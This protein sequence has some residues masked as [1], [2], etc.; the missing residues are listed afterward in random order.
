MTF[1][2]VKVEKLASYGLE[3]LQRQIV[4]PS[5]ITIKSGAEFQGALGDAIT[6]KIGARTKARRAKIRPATEAER[7]IQFSDLSEQKTHVTLTDRIYSAVGLEDEKAKLDVEDVFSQVVAPQVRAIAVDYENL[8]A[9]EIAGAPY[10]HVVPVD[11]DHPYEA[12]VEA[13]RLLGLSFVPDENR[14]L[15]VGANFEAALRK[16]PQ[17]I[18]ATSAGDAIASS[19]LA[20]AT[21]GTINGYTVVKSYALPANEAYIIHKSAFSSAWLAPVV[22]DGASW[23]KSIGLGGETGISLTWLKDYDFMVGRDRSLL[24][25]YTGVNTTIDEPDVNA[26]NEIVAA[27]G[28]LRAVKLVLP[29][30]TSA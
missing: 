22:P 29:G 1:N 3:L 9:E 28:F 4:L 14:T 27:G 10:K 11:P 8:L 6:I 23:G 13:N 2:A 18:A 20:R 25:F 5:R 17:F 16:S 7:Q 26:D 12:F 21:L 19:L 15:L 24:H 30:D